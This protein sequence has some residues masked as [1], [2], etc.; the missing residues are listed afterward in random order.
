MAHLHSAGAIALVSAG[1]PQALSCFSNVA[2]DG[3]AFGACSFSP[4]DL[5]D[6]RCAT[7]SAAAKWAMVNGLDGVDF[8]IQAPGSEF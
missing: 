3:T 2:N 8:Y 4:R 1:G 6:A 7:G 5:L